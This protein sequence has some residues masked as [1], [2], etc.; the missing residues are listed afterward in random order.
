VIAPIRIMGDRKLGT[1][2]FVV[3]SGLV[4]RPTRRCLWRIVAKRK[5][6]P[7]ALR[8]ASRLPPD[9]GQAVIHLDAAALVIVN[10][11]GE[12]LQDNRK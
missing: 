8:L 2:G 6:G 1:E 7:D 4:S 5:H 10:R 11:K 3:C 12:I 9:E